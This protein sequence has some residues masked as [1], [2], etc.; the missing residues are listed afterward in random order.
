MAENSSHKRKVAS[1]TLAGSTK[2]MPEW[3]NGRRTSLKM[4]RPLWRAGSNPVSGTNFIHKRSVAQSGRAE[5][6][7]R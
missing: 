6:L 2:Y 3:R 5:R 7:G 1:S 4:R